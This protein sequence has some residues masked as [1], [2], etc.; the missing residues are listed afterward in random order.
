MTRTLEEEDSIEGWGNQ[1]RCFK[2]HLAHGKR[3][4]VSLL[5]NMQIQSCGFIKNLEGKNQ[6][7]LNIGYGSKEEIKLLKCHQPMDLGIW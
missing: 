6:Q 3:L 5:V 1:S 2:N 7:N 4:V